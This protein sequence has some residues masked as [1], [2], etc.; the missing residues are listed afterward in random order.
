MPWKFHELDLS[1]IHVMFQH[2]KQINL[3]KWHGIYMEFGVD[4]D[5]TIPS[6]CDME[7]HGVSIRIHVSFFTGWYTNV[8]LYRRK[9]DIPIKNLTWILMA[10]SMLFIQVLLVFHAQTWHGFRTSSSHRMSLAF[11]E[12][13][14]GFPSDLISFST[15]LPS[16]RHET[17]RVTNYRVQ[18]P[19]L[20]FL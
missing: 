4:L 9:S 15:K 20:V 14:S 13:M 11:A 19:V 1:K 5:Q 7:W 12:K 17:I 8:P 6:I 3:D 16:K 10:N 2:G 18:I